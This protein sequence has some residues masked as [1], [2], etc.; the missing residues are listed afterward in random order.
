[1]PLRVASQLR[2]HDGGGLRRETGALGQHPVLV[3][4]FRKLRSRPSPA[5]V[6]PGTRARTL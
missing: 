1:M 4:R 2:L 3:V 6:A 5:R